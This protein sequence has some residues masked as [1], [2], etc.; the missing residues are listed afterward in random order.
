MKKI[1]KQAILFS[2]LLFTFSSCTKD[3]FGVEGCGPITN[4]ERQVGDF[5]GV[6]LDLDG[7]VK[8][9]QDSV[10][11]VS[12]TTFENYHSLVQT[13]VRDGHL[14]IHSSK[15]LESDQVTVEVHLPLIDYLAVEGS[16]SM[17][18]NG[19][20]H[21]DQLRVKVSGS[22]KLDFAGS[23]QSIEARVTGSGDV[24]L[25][26]SVTNAKYT[27]EGSG[28]IKGYS[29]PNAFCIS[30]ISGSGNIYTN[31]STSLNVSISGSGNVYYMNYPAIT[32]HI[33]GSGNV[34]HVN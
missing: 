1:K 18:N 34:I 10:Y 3:W 20:F 29:F 17:F 31:S 8:V 23:V 33:T 26:G 27:I 2:L 24:A 12:V 28:S 4:S 32:S 7:H 11:S 14:F 5:T 19:Y 16:G 21:C 25:N 22:G 15:M 6:D 30:T 9:V 13:Y